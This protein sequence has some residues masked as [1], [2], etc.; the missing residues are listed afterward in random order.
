LSELEYKLAHT[1]ENWGDYGG[2]GIKIL[3]AAGRELTRDDDYLLGHMAEQIHDGIMAQTIKLDPETAKNRAVER[4][5]II[6]LFPSPIFVEEIAN[7]Y[8]SRW[9]CLQKPWFVVTTSRGRIKIG[10]RKRVLQI[11]WDGSTIKET[12]DDLFPD[13]DVTKEG[14]L[15]HA[16]G[17]EKARKYIGVLLTN[18]PADRGPGPGE[19]SP[20]QT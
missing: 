18:T 5:E 20:R 19:D 9:C 2:L 10:W 15:I 4:A 7:G 12:A 1:S 6:G 13:E 17:Y 3:I 11:E 16:W 8:C 14:R